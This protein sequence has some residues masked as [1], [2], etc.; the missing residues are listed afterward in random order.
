MF[1]KGRRRGKNIVAIYGDIPEAKRVVCIMAHY[2]TKSSL[3]PFGIRVSMMWLAVLS[4]L[5]S[6]LL[7]L[8]GLCSW[9]KAFSFAAGMFGIALSFDIPQNKSPGAID[10][11]SGLGIMMEIGR[12]AS[13]Y[14]P[15][16]LGLIFVATD[17]E[18]D[19]MIGALRFV[20]W[21]KGS[22]LFRS[23]ISFLNIDISSGSR[24]VGISGKRGSRMAGEVANAMRAEGLRPISIPLIG[25]GADHIPAI[26][27]GFDA[28]TVHG[29]GSISDLFRIHTG[30]D[31]PRSLLPDGMERIGRAI[32]NWIFK[33]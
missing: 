18:E 24:W 30:M 14:K 33:M 9:A 29:L 17:A 11:A 13:F 27:H 23:D 12:M 3:F 22:Q 1:G 20:E 16:G 6:S 25:A 21:F 26:W 32:V 10:N 19:G 31:L 28:I 8:S 15:E 7:I 4:L 5:S 2:D